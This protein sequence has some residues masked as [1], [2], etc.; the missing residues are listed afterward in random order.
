M[1]AYSPES[2]PTVTFNRMGLVTRCMFLKCKSIFIRVENA[3]KFNHVN[4]WGTSVYLETWALLMAQMVEWSESCLV[5]SYDLRPHGLYRPWN[6]PGWNTGESSCSLLQRIFPTQESN[7]CL[8]RCTWILYQLSYQGSHPICLQCRRPGSD[9]WVRKSPW[10]RKGQP[11]QVFLP[12]E[13]H[14]QRSLEG[15]SPWSCKELDTAEW[16][17]HT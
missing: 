12:G 7:W 15:Y 17:R 2:S 3:P 1:T 13:S 9:P 14:R 6:S 10:R 8:P 5:V 4:H 11:S 16:I